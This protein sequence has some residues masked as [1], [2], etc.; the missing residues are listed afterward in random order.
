MGEPGEIVFSGICVG[1]GYVNDPERTRAAYMAD[2]HRPGQR[3]YR[4]GDFGRWRPDGKLEYLG[5][6][7]SQV[8]IRGFRIEIGEIENTLLG[9]PGVGDAA[10]V[11]G[12][13][14]GSKYLAAFYSGPAPVAVDSLTERLGASL[15]AYMVPTAFH[16][17]ATLPLTPNG[18]VDRKA[19][20]ALAAESDVVAVRRQGTLTPTEQRLA[21]AWAQV[22]GIPADQIDRA[23]DFFELG[24]TSLSAV[25]LA[26]LLDRAVPLGALKRR[27]VLADMASLLEEQLTRT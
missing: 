27:P 17:T 8:K 14:G 6:R 24:G 21:G 16:W 12:E 13:R 26:V 19:L 5:R 15:P 9:V 3:L 11:V 1:R 20:T 2:P 7:D 22:L 4:S 23:D 18:K 25:K 10:V